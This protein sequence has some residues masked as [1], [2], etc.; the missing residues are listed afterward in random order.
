MAMVAVDW[1]EAMET[2][3]LVI[4][5]ALVKEAA[6]AETELS[7]RQTESNATLAGCPQTAT[8]T[9]NFRGAVMA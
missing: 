7:N 6:S 5:V 1:D 9:A 8:S 2:K 4:R 3:E